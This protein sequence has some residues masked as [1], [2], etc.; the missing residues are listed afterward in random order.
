MPRWVSCA[1]HFTEHHAFLLGMMLDRIDT[2]TAQIDTLTARI[3]QAI[4]PFAAQVAQLDEIPGIGVTTA[5][6]ILAETGADMTRFPAPGHL[7][8]WAKFAPKAR[9]SAARFKAAATGKGNPWLG[10]TIG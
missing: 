9:Q 4:A 5:Q 7:V 10:G 3:E 1:G 6:E 2:L 8:S